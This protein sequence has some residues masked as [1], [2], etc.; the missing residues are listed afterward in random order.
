MQD[1]FG[2]PQVNQDEQQAHGDRS[3]GQGFGGQECWGEVQALE[4]LYSGHQDDGRGGDAD[5]EQKIGDV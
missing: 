3:N 1:A 5:Q 4:Q 2:V